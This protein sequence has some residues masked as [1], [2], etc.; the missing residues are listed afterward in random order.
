MSHANESTSSPN[1]AVEPKREQKAEAAAK[2][3]A[4]QV[5][6]PETARLIQALEIER[7]GYVTRG[8]TD[9]VAQVDA[10]LKR[11]RGGK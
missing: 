8:K 6:D 3:A 4:A 1:A 2:R 9:R 10:Q 7:A 11:L 5:G